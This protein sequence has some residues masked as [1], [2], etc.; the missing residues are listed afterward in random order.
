MTEGDL[1]ML[2]K[3]M[4]QLHISDL[5][6]SHLLKWIV[7]S[8]MV[9]YALSQIALASWFSPLSEQHTVVLN[10]SDLLCGL[11]AVMFLTLSVSQPVLRLMS[12]LGEDLSADVIGKTYFVCG[13]VFFVLCLAL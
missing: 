3:T 9:L 7:V 5:L 2:T 12:R 6:N 10:D 1:T 11:L 8:A 4:T 13:G